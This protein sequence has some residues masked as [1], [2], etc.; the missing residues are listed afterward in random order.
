MSQ[1]ADVNIQSSVGMFFMMS[2]I[3]LFARKDVLGSLYCAAKFPGDFAMYRV[4]QKT[5]PYFNVDNFLVV[6][7]W[8]CA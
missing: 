1:L 7:S 6:M 8:R 2:Y 4:G 5:G 3:L